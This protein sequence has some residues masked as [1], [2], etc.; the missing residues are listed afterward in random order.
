M[1]F[2]DALATDLLSFPSD[3]TK[4]QI[5]QVDDLLLM[6]ETCSQCWE[7]TKTPLGLLGQAG[8]QVS[9]K[10]AQICQ[11]EAKFLGFVIKQSRCTLGLE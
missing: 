6:A 11:T 7:G 4:C 5:L 10:K 3:A 8:Y 1:I 2:G 9:W